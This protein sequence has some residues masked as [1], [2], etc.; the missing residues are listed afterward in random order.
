MYEVIVVWSREPLQQLSNVMTAGESWGQPP[1][2][3]WP[4]R[5]RLGTINQGTSPQLGTQGKDCKHG[6]EHKYYGVNETG[7]V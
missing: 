5:C 3:D 7:G 6:P 4:A 2:A 1:A